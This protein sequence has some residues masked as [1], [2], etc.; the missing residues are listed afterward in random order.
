MKHIILIVIFSLPGVAQP[1]EPQPAREEGLGIVAKLKSNAEALQHYAYRRR[2]SITTKDKSRTRLELVRYVDGK[3]ETVPL[4]SP[5]N[6]ARSGGGR[7]R[8]RGMLGQ[9]GGQKREEMREQ[10]EQLNTMFRSYT[11]PEGLQPMFAK[12]V[13][14][15]EGTPPNIVIRASATG[16]V[17]PSD[18][19][20]WLWS[21]EHQRPNK[22]EIQTEL[23]GK[24]VSMTVEFAEVANGPFYPAHVTIVEPKKD[25]TVNIDQYDVA[26]AGQ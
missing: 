15:R 24:P 7:G 6:A 21:V 2:T 10:V 9:N 5:D 1:P 8:R 13:V 19:V 20:T 22:I 18:S 11:A 17:Q 14:S 3:M 12:A 25:I 23:D 16:V 26:P 4:D